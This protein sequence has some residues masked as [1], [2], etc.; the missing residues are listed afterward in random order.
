M[1]IKQLESKSICFSG[2]VKIHEKVI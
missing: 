1:H 2:S